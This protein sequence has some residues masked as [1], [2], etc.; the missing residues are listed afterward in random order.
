MICRAFISALTISIFLLV[1]VKHDSLGNI[2]ISYEIV[3]ENNNSSQLYWKEQTN[4]VKHLTH[5][6][7]PY[8]KVNSVAT[9]IDVDTY[10]ITIVPITNKD[11]FNLKNIQIYRPG[12]FIDLPLISKQKI[13]LLETQENKNIRSINDEIFDFK[14]LSVNPLFTY[15]IDK[16]NIYPIYF[17]LNFLALFLLFHI[18]FSVINRFAMNNPHEQNHKI[19]PDSFLIVLLICIYFST[20]LSFGFNNPFA[21]IKFIC[22]FSLVCY[23]CYLFAS[24]IKK[25]NL[26]ITPVI[27]T[28]IV[29]FLLIPDIT[30]KFG[31][32]N[33]KLYSNRYT[34]VYHWR[35]PNSAKNNLVQSGHLYR[36]DMVK[37][38]DLVTPGT[39]FI[40]DPVTS[41]YALSFLPIYSSVAKSHHGGSRKE[42][43]S[44][45]FSNEFQKHLCSN[46]KLFNNQTM[47]EYIL[48]KIRLREQKK[49]PKLKYILLNKDTTNRFVRWE[50]M[51]ANNF[52]T[53]SKV[54]EISKLIF[55]GEHIN[56]YQIDII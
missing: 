25:E 45:F 37:I 1:L 34:P 28:A 24:V 43:N 48:E 10:K 38:K 39:S 12:L 2:I 31:I 8:P 44:P 15:L 21:S 49:W 56:L 55:E 9:H 26:F 14:S 53:V 17:I 32:I 6:I 52:N 54:K 36:H 35:L 7:S 5:S 18:S 11:K 22:L 33:N 41:Y 4:T 50:C 23:L 42:R 27:V 19:H 13:N 20:K 29:L 3:T 51:S 46:S 30:Y 16:K 40:S 47:K